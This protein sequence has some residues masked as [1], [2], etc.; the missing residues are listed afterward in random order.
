V[1]FP[2]TPS[3]TGFSA[4]SCVE[5]DVSHLRLIDGEVPSDLDGA[6]FRVAPDPQ[7][8][9]LAGDDIWF[10]GDGMVSRFRFKDGQIKLT[11][12]WVRTAKFKRERKVG[13]ALF[14]AYR[15][16]LTDDPS[17][18]GVVRG[19]ANTN[20]MV[21]AGKLFALKEDSPP[22]V[23][24]PNT[25]E[26][27]GEWDFN[28]NLT[29][30]TFTA[31]PKVDPRSGEML[32]FGYAAKGLCTTDMAFYVISPAG[33]IV[34]ER[35]FEL[36]YYCMMHDFGFTADYVLFH[37]VPIVGSWERLRAGLPHFGFDRGKPVHLG[38]MPRK[39]GGGSIRWF[40]APT[41]F[42]SHVMNA[43]NEGA[44]IHFDVPTS[45]GNM[46]P[47][48]P[49]TAGG[50]FQPEEAYGRMTRWTVD[51]SSPS[52]EIRME[53]FSEL[54]G[55]FPRIDERAAG[56]RYRHGWQLVQ[57]LEKPVDLAGGRS[58]AGLMMNSLGHIDLRTDRRRCR[59]SFGRIRH[60]HNTSIHP[61]SL[62][63][64]SPRRNFTAPGRCPGTKPTPGSAPIWSSVPQ[65]T[66]FASSASSSR[67]PMKSTSSAFKWASNSSPKRCCGWAD[68]MS[69]RARGTPSIITDST[70]KRISRVRTSS[71]GKTSR[72]S[73]RSTLPGRCSSRASRSAG[74]ARFSYP[75]AWAP[76]RL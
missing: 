35:W 42:A 54:I 69:P 40:T 73:S 43:F 23:M 22:V 71:A 37:V 60:A 21:F 28:G 19:T 53:R 3:F 10:N 62:R 17:V 31:H 11:Q 7:F 38:V 8:P 48:F 70:C 51:M 13:R 24:D 52:N 68:S 66:N 25:L 58:A 30:Q 18:A 32:A 65:N 5:A 15:N 72:G 26:T 2:D 57:D 44:T 67:R 64:L 12:R 16:P 4:P 6:F 9:P 27:V 1:K 75:G 49:D 39:P 74:R 55:E 63:Y 29:S 20:V 50:P 46:F 41:V 76:R 45:P 34:H 61:A 59:P 56:R 33:E 14:G 36:P 47:F